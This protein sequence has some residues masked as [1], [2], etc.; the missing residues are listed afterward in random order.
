MTV[1]ITALKRILIQPVNW[2]FI[3]LFP[4]VFAVLIA[5]ASF[6]GIVDGDAAAVTLYFGVVD[7]DGSALSH[8]LTEQLRV[9]FDVL[10]LEE[11]DISATLTEQEVP[12]ILL[13]RPGYERDILEGREPV[14]EG[15]SLTISDVSAL[16]SVTARNITRALLLLGTNQEAALRAWEEASAVEVTTAELGSDWGLISFW[17]GFFGFVAVFTAYFIIKTLTDEKRGGMPDRLGVLPQSPRLY[18]VQGTLSAFAATEIT[19]LL[20]MAVLQTIY[21][22]IPNAL[23]LFGLL[24]VY[25]LFAVGMVLAVIYVAKDMGAASVTMTM[26]STVMAMLGGLFWPLD[27]VPPFMRRLAW[28]SPGYWLTEGLANMEEITLTGYGLPMLFLTGFAL[29]TLLLGGWKRIQ[30]L[31]E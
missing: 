1:F 28:F 6:N 14:L 26:L 23:P 24:S 4:T 30:A 21:G 9:R 16:G 3:L 17:F 31:E 29:V 15:Y 13:I 12:W 11:P 7:Q 22:S 10:E 18:L 19:V 27:F 2:A 25:N 8:R 5:T 20:L